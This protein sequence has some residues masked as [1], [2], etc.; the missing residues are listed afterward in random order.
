MMSKIKTHLHLEEGYMNNYEKL[1]KCVTVIFQV[2]GKHGSCIGCGDARAHTFFQLW[3]H[4]YAKQIPVSTNTRFDHPQVA[5]GAAIGNLVQT[6]LEGEGLA[7]EPLIHL[8]GGGWAKDE[9]GNLILKGHS[10]GC[11]ATHQCLPPDFQDLADLLE[12]GG[13]ARL[14]AQM[15]WNY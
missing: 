15:N 8:Q 1:V 9:K 3:L 12:E 7:W 14:K 4:G 6:V 10:N 2:L 13:G 11:Y 5:L